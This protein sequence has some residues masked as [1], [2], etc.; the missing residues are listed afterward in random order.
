MA[1]ISKEEEDVV[2]QVEWCVFLRAVDNVLV[3]SVKR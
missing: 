2:G 3:C 1:D